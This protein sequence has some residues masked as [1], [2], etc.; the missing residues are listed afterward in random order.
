MYIFGDPSHVPVIHVERHVLDFS[1]HASGRASFAISPKGAGEKTFLKQ[2][3]SGAHNNS[4]LLKVVVFVH[5]FQVRPSYHA[6]LHGEISNSYFK[7][8]K[9][10]EI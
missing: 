9:I 8:K 6:N 2:S 4:R 7:I 3:V 10:L 1:M 5:G